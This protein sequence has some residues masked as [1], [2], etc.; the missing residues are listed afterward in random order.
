MKVWDIIIDVK[1]V[2]WISF[3]VFW[4]SIIVNVK[5][6]TWIRLSTCEG[7]CDVMFIM[8]IMIGISVCL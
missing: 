8:N 4:N 3:C 2:V 6:A 7:G 1:V 5:V